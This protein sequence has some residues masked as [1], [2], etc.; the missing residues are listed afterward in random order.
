MFDAECSVGSMADFLQSEGYATDEEKDERICLD[1][2]SRCKCKTYHNTI[3]EGSMRIMFYTWSPER[4]PAICLLLSTAS[5]TADITFLSWNEVYS[6][7]SVETFVSKRAHAL[8]SP[9]AIN[10]K[11]RDALR[12]ENIPI[13]GLH[14]D[15]RGGGLLG[16][17]TSITRRRRI[18]DDQT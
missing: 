9:W 11:T 1:H 5:T 12:K 18:G 4:V 14:W 8:Q 15:Q 13:S 16:N 17:S 10:L 7:F 2:I 6:L 3:H